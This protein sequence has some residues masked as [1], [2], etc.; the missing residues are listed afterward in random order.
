MPLDRD[1]PE[2]MVGAAVVN[3]ATLMQAKK[4]RGEIEEAREF[5]TRAEL[6]ARSGR[7]R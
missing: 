7:R 4:H 1:F 5:R 2:V 6:T 3:A